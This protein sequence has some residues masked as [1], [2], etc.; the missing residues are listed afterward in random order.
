MCKLIYEKYTLYI[1]TS[2]DS[3]ETYDLY[4][5]IYVDMNI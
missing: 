2:K 4:M 5:D 3:Q 1:N